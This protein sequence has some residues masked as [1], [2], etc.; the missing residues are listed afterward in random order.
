MC[1]RIL[2]VREAAIGGEELLGGHG[3]ILKGRQ[4]KEQVV[5]CSG[6]PVTVLCSM[7]PKCRLRGNLDGFVDRKTCASLVSAWLINQSRIWP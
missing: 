6:D 3:G 4:S 5:V 7:C 1:P 2:A